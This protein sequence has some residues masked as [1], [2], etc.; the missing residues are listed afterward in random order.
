MTNQ[1]PFA[2]GMKGG[3]SAYHIVSQFYSAWRAVGCSWC[4]L[5]VTLSKRFCRSEGSGPAARRVFC[6][7]IMARPA[8]F[9]IKLHHHPVI[10]NS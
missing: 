5:I 8:R 1:A 4:S 6:D 7:A 3:D 10:P 9:L 2:S